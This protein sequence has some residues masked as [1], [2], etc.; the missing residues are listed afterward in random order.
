LL[1]EIVLGDL[2]REFGYKVNEVMCLGYFEAHR[3]W[4]ILDE[5][6]ARD[7][8]HFSHVLDSSN[9]AEEY[10]T[11]VDEWLKKRQPR[12]KPGVEPVPQE[13][14]DKFAEAFRR[15]R[16]QGNDRTKP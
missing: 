15:G 2:V 8:Q 6:K 1:E 12:G 5:L 3:L 7:L 4:F 16:Q 14:L 13:V 11:N 9:A 10:R